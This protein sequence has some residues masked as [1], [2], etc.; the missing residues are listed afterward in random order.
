MKRSIVL[1]CVGALALGL[2]APATA[3]KVKS[4]SA[5]VTGYNLGFFEGEVRS[6]FDL[7]EER[8]GV[9][10]WEDLPDPATDT[11]LGDDKTDSE[12]AWSIVDTDGTGG[13]YYAV[14]RNKKGQYRDAR[15]ERRKYQCPEVTSKPFTR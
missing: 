4:S 12:G 13:T 8:R 10:L 2:A 1:A 14:A 9:E 15:G 11:L 7:C 5:K 3:G 6:R